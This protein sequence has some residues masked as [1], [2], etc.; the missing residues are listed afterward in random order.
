MAKGTVNKVIVLG[1][2]GKNP[3]VRYMPSG[4]AAV[5]LSI[6]TNDGYKDKQTG[7]YID[8]TEWHRVVFFGKQAEVVGQYCEKG[9][10]IYIEGR[11]RTNKWQDQQG[12]E[13]QTVEIV[14]TE[15]QLLSGNKK[16]DDN[17][18]EVYRPSSATIPNNYERAKQGR[19][20]VQQP[21]VEKLND[22]NDDDIPF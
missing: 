9:N 12:N 7:Q 21:T 19:T 14:C 13:R 6:A 17:T 8:V 4:T 10:K 18:Q 20:I 11:L 2:I 16:S 3:E 15:M 1:T 22:F 5:N